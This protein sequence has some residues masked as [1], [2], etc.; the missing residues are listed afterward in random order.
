MK[1]A[2]AAVLA[3]LPGV[4]FA[5]AASNITGLITQLQTW[6]NLLIPLLLTAAIVVFFWGLVKYIMAAGDEGAKE[7]G[8]TLMIWGM[9]ALFVMVAFWGIIGYFQSSLGLTGTVTTTAA[10]VINPVPVAP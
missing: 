1:K 10:P 2:Y 7:S 8:K 4:A 3:A 5:Q 9:I 6:L